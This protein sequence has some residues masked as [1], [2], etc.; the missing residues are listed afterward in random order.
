MT[1]PDLLSSFCDRLLKS[2][3]ERLTDSEVEEALE[4]TV[5]LFGYMTDKDV[6]SEIYRCVPSPFESPSLSSVCFAC[7]N[8]LAKRLLNQRSSSDEMERAMVNL[9]SFVC[10]RRLK[11]F[12][13]GWKAQSALWRAVYGEDGRNAQRSVSR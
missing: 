4:N 7:R 13:S 11:S 8:Q 2:G 9:I 3:G 5:Q 10:V 6:F 12:V 1:M